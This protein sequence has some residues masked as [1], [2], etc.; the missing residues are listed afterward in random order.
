VGR[1]PERS[2]KPNAQKETPPFE[3][4]GFRRLCDAGKQGMR[5]PSAIHAVEALDLD[6]LA[7]ILQRNVT[8]SDFVKPEFPTKSGLLTSGD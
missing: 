2:E 6:A 4:R 3:G 1:S 5:C 7:T 8:E